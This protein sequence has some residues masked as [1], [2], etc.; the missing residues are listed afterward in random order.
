[1]IHMQ[2]ISNKGL[3]KEE[4]DQ[5]AETLN[6]K[7]RGYL[8]DPIHKTRFFSVEAHREPRGVYAK[9][10]LQNDNQSFYYP[11][12][13]RL[14]DLDHDFS[15]KDGLIF[16]FD[17]VD[18]YFEEFLKNSDVYLPI[19]WTEHEYE[20]IPFQIKGQVYNLYLERMA[21]RLLGEETLNI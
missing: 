14:A 19:E 8:S 16:L 18:S 21:D 12:E 4:L 2:E 9:V 3:S 13:I 11:I 15:M 7:Y 10:I 6:R 5:I 20:G 1:M 17:Y